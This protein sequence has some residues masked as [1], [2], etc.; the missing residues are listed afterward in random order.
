M[1]CSI[2]VFGVLALILAGCGSTGDAVRLPSARELLTAD[3]ISRTSA[4]TAYEAI[5]IRRP[6][7]L[8][9]KGPKTTDPA[10]RS[11]MYPAV[12]LNGVYYGDVES[13]KSL[14]VSDIRDISYI[15]PQEATIMFGSGHVA[16]V[17]MVN[18]K[19]N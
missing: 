15:D 13:L 3:E 19:N 9:M 8:R 10:T 18:T 6:A 2:A 5:R 4:L 16:G 7:Y 14:Y 12:Y 1:R 17:I 11:T